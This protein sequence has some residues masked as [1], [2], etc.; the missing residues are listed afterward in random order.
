VQDAARTGATE[1]LETPAPSAE[2]RET[3][4]AVAEQGLGA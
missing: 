2:G 1:R 4:A 3:A